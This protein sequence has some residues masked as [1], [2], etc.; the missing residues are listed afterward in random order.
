MSNIFVHQ[1]VSPGRTGPGFT[2][3]LCSLFQL[4]ELE[5]QAR[6]W[7][8]VGGTQKKLAQ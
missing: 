2:S 1:A 7:D 4:P 6:V 3:Q 5:P 8:I